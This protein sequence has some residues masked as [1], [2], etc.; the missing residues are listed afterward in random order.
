[1]KR[2]A[3]CAALLAAVAAEAQVTTRRGRVNVGDATLSWAST[4]SG[5]PIVFIHGYAQHQGIWD[6]QV[7]AFAPRFR[8]VRYDVRG[9]AES[10]G[11][12]DASANPE[13]LRLL[14]DALGVRKAHIVGLSMGADVALRF[15]VL[16]PE[17]VDG[18]VLYGVPPTPDAPQPVELFPLFAALP[19]LARSHGL[20]TVGKLIIAS[21]LGW[22]PPERPEL[23]EKLFRDWAKF[24]GRDLLDPRPPSGRTPEIDLTHVSRLRMPTLIVHGDHEVPSFR[25]FA[26]TLARRIRHAKRAVIT[27]GG[28]GAHFAQPAQFNKALSDFFSSFPETRTG[29]LDVGDATI[30]YASTGSG[31]AIVF[32]HGWSQHLGI[33]D[34]QATAFSPRYRVIRYDSRGFGESTGHADPTAEPDDLRALLDSLGIARAHVV[35]LSRGANIALRFAVLFPQRVETV[36]LYGI[37]PI[38]GFRSGPMGPPLRQEFA[39]IARQYGLDSLGKHVRASDLA[40]RPADRPDIT[41]LYERQWRDYKGR[42]LLDPRPP[43]GRTREIRLEDVNGMRVPTLIV[44][45]DHEMPLF[46]QVADTLVHRLPTAQKVVIADG[47]HGAH[48]AQPERFNAA[49]RDFFDLVAKKP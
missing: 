9:F 43:S 15:A 5:Q 3:M 41:D 39:R 31:P 8:V 30:H 25:A 37:G 18:L 6:D 40:W 27:N 2:L 16:F 34:D 26:D 11:H 20:D 48:F 45:G 29:R 24:D 1:M 23:T 4:G 44:H 49:L 19:A 46:R 7:A 10:T 47:G 17:R 38:P 13:D 14:L 22:M 33:W 42:D 32:I 35:G 21:P 36:V 28:H 12:P